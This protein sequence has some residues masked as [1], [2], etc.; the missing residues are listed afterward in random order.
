MSSPTA[1]SER[2][3]VVPIELLPS[4]YA[5]ASGILETKGAF[6][7]MPSVFESYKSNR[8]PH[9]SSANISFKSVTTGHNHVITARAQIE[10]ESVELNDTR[11]SDTAKNFLVQKGWDE[12]FKQY[13]QY[14]IEYIVLG[15][16][17][18]LSAVCELKDRKDT[19][20]LLKWRG[21]ASDLKQPALENVEEFCRNIGRHATRPVP[22]WVRL[23]RF[24][25]VAEFVRCRDIPLHFGHKLTTLL[26][27]RQS[28]Y[29]KLITCVQI[30][31]VHAEETD[32]ISILEKLRALLDDL[33]KA[34]T[35]CDD[36]SFI[37]HIGEIR[38]RYYELV[39]LLPQNPHR[40]KI[41]KLKN[42][43]SFPIHVS[44]KGYETRMVQ[45][46]ATEQWHL[47]MIFK[48]V[49]NVKVLR[50]SWFRHDKML[51]QTWLWDPEI[52]RILY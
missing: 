44:I 51:Y 18:S 41:I 39:H 12:F 9:P 46:G 21:F 42:Q 34:K 15:G 24:D 35:K 26:H 43:A 4:G 23:C 33:Q 8:K 16:T 1:K 30:A 31:I 48:D 13:G 11:I 52:L 19:Y 40:R 50:K 25:E 3:T 38:F 22:L 47:P 20:N 29:E 45:K 32:S 2:I 28:E 5:L 36:A 37:P 14:Y 7:I 6:K 10:I 27:E 17:F 49:Y